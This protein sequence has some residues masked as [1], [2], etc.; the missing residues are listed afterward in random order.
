[1]NQIEFTQQELS[2]FKEELFKGF[3]DAQFDLAI[4]ECRRRNL[5]PGQHIW[6]QLRTVKE[7]DPEL[8]VSN[9][10]KKVTRITTIDAFRLISQ[11]TGEYEGQ[12]E[13]EFIY[14]DENRQPTI[15]SKI[16]LP[17]PELDNTPREP[18]AVCVPIYRRGFKEPV[19]V[20]AR[21]DAYAVTRKD[22]NKVV[23]TDMW[24]RRGPE[25]LAKCGEAAGRRVAFPEELGS[26]YLS[27]EF[28]KEDSENKPTAEPT[29]VVEAPKAA[30]VPQVNN[31]PA[32]PTEAARPGEEEKT[33][34]KPRTPKKPSV[35]DAPVEPATPVGATD[36]DLPESMFEEGERPV[37]IMDNRLPTPEENAEIVA[38]VRG[39]YDFSTASVVGKY[40]LGFAGVSKSAEIPYAKWQEVFK[41]LDTAHEQG[42]EAFVTLLT[43]KK[44]G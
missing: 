41:L 43:A 2:A 42:K 5:V 25:Q 35:S 15:V 33:E 30:V 37:H 13:A 19:R 18:W 17:H 7:W 23:L 32:K 10:T 11:R 16:P 12:G 26:M 44:E 8:R 29:P 22:N 14:L 40:V 3:T 9:T 6:F 31:E 24:L 4:E 20:V 34:R 28:Q 27:E 38:K 39:Y 21:F 1:M 36:E